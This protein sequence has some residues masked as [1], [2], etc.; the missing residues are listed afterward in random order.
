M[1]A[2]ETTNLGFDYLVPHMMEHNVSHYRN[3]YLYVTEKQLLSILKNGE[4]K[5]SRTTQTNDSTENVYRGFSSVH[6]NVRQYGYICLSRTISSPMMWG[7]YAD[8][9]RGA[10]LVFS[11]KFEQLPMKGQK[12]AAH[13]SCAKMWRVSEFLDRTTNQVAYK[14]IDGQI[15]EVNYAQKRLTAPEDIFCDVGDVMATKGKEWEH[16]QEM[17]I[18]Y[19]LKPEYRSKALSLVHEMRSLETLYYSKDIT[20]LLSRVVLGFNSRFDNL[21]D[22][23]ERIN[24]NMGTTAAPICVVKASLNPECFS[25][26]SNLESVA[27]RSFIR[28]KSLGIQL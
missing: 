5:L 24:A 25:I 20:P 17:R 8:R 11:A 12:D 19:N 18:L 22:L 13:A 21:S 10:C 1:D 6:E 3:L 2:K 15:Y 4:L 14:N 16:E 7:L 28:M 27:N 23:E 9:G 26:D